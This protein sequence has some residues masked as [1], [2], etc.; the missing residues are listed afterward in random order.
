[1][2]SHPWANLQGICWLHKI[3]LDVLKSV[4]VFVCIKAMDEVILKFLSIF[5]QYVFVFCLLQKQ[6]FSNFRSGKTA[7]KSVR[8][9][10]RTDMV[11]KTVKN[12]VL[13][14]FY[15]T[16]VFD[17]SKGNA[18]FFT[19]DRSFVENKPYVHIKWYSSVRAYYTQL[20][21]NT[22]F[23]VPAKVYLIHYHCL[24]Y[25]LFAIL[26]Q[27]KK[28]AVKVSIKHLSFC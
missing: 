2:K 12:G 6:Y 22:S 10:E 4:S 18:V 14:K 27:I 9:H 8:V 26:Q 19:A 28:I 17:H 16:L 3:P 13:I 15:M 1:M 11:F 20:Y 7:L 25:A 24:H 23:S 5:S 21:G